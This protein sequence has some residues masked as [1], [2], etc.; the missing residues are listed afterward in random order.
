MKHIYIILL[1]LAVTSCTK[2]IYPKTD[3][4][5]DTTILEIINLDQYTFFKRVVYVDTTRTNFYKGYDS[6]K[7]TIQYE[8]QFIA[9]EKTANSEGVKNFFQ[10]NYIPPY[11]PKGYDS[12]V[13]D[14]IP[15]EDEN[16]ININFINYFQFG[17]MKGNQVTLKR[18][19]S[20]SIWKVSESSNEI[21][22]DELT[23]L[24]RGKMK[25]VKPIYYLKNKPQYKIVNPTI[26]F[27][28]YSGLP[29]NCKNTDYLNGNIMYYKLSTNEIFFNF[30]E[31]LN[32]GENDT[33][34]MF[35]KSRVKA[36]YIK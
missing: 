36:R 32:V 19:K 3:M 18:E 17:K 27:H 31:E 5:V 35:D 1:L 9:V 23:F 15:F 14:M 29:I 24:D 8:I 28:A 33:W 21:S 4:Q 6:T 30:N 34:I 7:G 16:L 12:F 13:Y 20:I 10:F 25:T 2:K 26:V 11:I 22:I